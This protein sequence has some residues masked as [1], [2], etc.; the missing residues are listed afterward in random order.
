MTIFTASVGTCGLFTKRTFFLEVRDK[1][2]K[3]SVVYGLGLAIEE[4]EEFLVGFSGSNTV[5]HCLGGVFDFLPRQG[6]A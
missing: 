2:L 6:T 4:L 5:D 3:L 1:C